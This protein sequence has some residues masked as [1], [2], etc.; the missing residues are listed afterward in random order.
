MKKRYLALL[1]AASVTFSSVLSGGMPQ[2]VMAAEA[3]G[4]TEEGLP[5]TQADGVTDHTASGIPGEDGTQADPSEKPDEPVNTQNPET[6]KTAG[7]ESTEAAGDT[8]Q[9]QEN[10][11][12]TETPE[13]TEAPEN[14]EGVEGTE[15]PGGTES[16]EGTETPEDTQ[17][18]ENT[19]GVEGTEGIEDTENTGDTEK[20][21]TGKTP[22][23]KQSTDLSDGEFQIVRPTGLIQP[24]VSEVADISNEQVYDIPDDDK[25]AFYASAVYASVWDKYSGNYIY[26]Q[27]SDEEQ[28]VWDA[29]DAMCLSYLTGN[30]NADPYKNKY[31]TKYVRCDGIMTWEGLVNIA[32]MFRFSNPQYYFLNTAIYGSVIGDTYY[33]AFGVYTAFV[34]GTARAAETAKVKAQA[35][36]WVALAS[37]YATNEQK[38]KA[39]HDVIV[40][41]VDYNDDI[42]QSG[43]DEDKAYSQSAYSVLCM[44]KTVCAGY[45][46]AFQMICNAV[47]VDSVSVTSYDHQWNKVRIND[48]WFNVDLTWADQEWGIYYELYGRSDAAYLQIDPSGSH[49]EEAYWYGNTPV[50]ILDSGS[51]QTAPGTFPVITATAVSPVITAKAD[52]DGVEVTITSATPGADIYYTVNGTQPSSAFTRSIK[53]T[54]SFIVK[55]GTNIKAIAVCDRY[56][57]SAVASKSAVDLSVTYKI[58]YKGNGST[59]GSMSTQTVTYGS[60][61]ALKGNAFKRKGYTFTGWNTKAD[62]SGKS[63]ADKADG[64]KLTTTQG[65]TITLYACWK[66]AKYKITYNLNGGKNN[67]G[68]P[69][70]YMITSATIKLKN[71]TRKGYKFGGWYTDS[72]YKKK[73]TQIAKGSTGGKTVYAKWIANTYTIK[74]VGNKSTSGKMSSTTGCKYGKNYTLK[75]NTFKKKGYIFNGWNT[76]ADGS[77]KSYKNKASVKNLTSKSKG[78][79]T[80]YAQWRKAKYTISYKLDGGKN[81]K[82]NP[83]SY[84][85]T[86]KTIKLK[87]PSKKGY[88]FV[89][90]YTDAKYKNKITEIKK[91]S[92][93]KINLYAKWKKK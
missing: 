39:I 29:M 25:E 40:Q 1:I 3:Q 89:G 79:V 32:Q 17:I 16:T 24:Q 35:E 63:Y 75:N 82:G 56:L 90:W 93:G 67:S 57:D 4:Q 72:K 54:D 11:E 80:L 14:T 60:G 21:E 8:Q 69:A 87:N 33:A 65:K 22:K 38:V 73:I 85:V 83:S 71:P 18:P 46:Q 10:P 28:A 45:S 59:S 62:G 34:N 19:E 49:N 15:T 36:A 61:T 50:G 9:P 6:E 68:N 31:I 44:N 23:E 91:G 78:T 53:Y 74:Y 92:T 12:G 26:N 20:P 84:T 42:Y 5:G 27:L 43:F 81:N 66:R 48:A 37:G 58:A 77:G 76:K 13:D 51:T 70:T 88:K 2:T 55:S 41:K 47:G 86:S 52:E 64:S 7:T 30:I